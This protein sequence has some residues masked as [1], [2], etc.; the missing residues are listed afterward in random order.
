[1]WLGPRSNLS[2]F[3]ES[4]LSHLILLVLKDVLSCLGLDRAEIAQEMSFFSMRPDIVVLKYMNAIVLIIEVKNAGQNAQKVMESESAAG[5]CLDYTYALKRTNIETPIVCLS[6]Y[7]MMRIGSSERS[8]QLILEKAKERLNN[9]TDENP[10]SSISAET[11]KLSPSPEKKGSA[12]EVPCDATEVPCDQPKLTDFPPVLSDEHSLG[13]KIFFSDTFKL[14][15]MFQALYLAVACGCISAE[16]S[17]L[18]NG[19]VYNLHHTSIPLEGEVLKDRWYNVVQ[20]DSYTWTK[21]RETKVTY[22]LKTNWV[23]NTRV[24]MGD[25]L[26]M[27]NTGKVY[28]C[29]DGK[30]RHFALKMLLYDSEVMENFDPERRQEARSKYMVEIEKVLKKEANRWKRIYP[31]Y[32][33]SI[34]NLILNKLPCF[35]M[36]Y[37]ASIPKKKREGLLGKIEKEMMRIAELGFA[38][39]TDDIRWRHIGLRMVNNEEEKIIFIDMESLVEVDGNKDH[40]H[41]VEFMKSLR[42]QM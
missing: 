41:L 17:Q 8:I 38:Y 42:E 10:F 31:E 28:L 1:M 30:G 3:N 7:T 20:K 24:F 9:V 37:I 27:G 13:R 18:A 33:K 21:V 6:T 19:D 2:N 39:K 4:S 32:K 22:A 5:Q 23:E 11:K 12:T 25:I 40:K 36:P 34:K 35:A 29:M 15:N 26:G 14:S 16:I